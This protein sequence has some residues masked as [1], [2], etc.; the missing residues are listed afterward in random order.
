MEWPE[1]IEEKPE[2]RID[3]LFNYEDN[4]TK[5]SLIISSANKKEL[6]DEFK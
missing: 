4:F 5:R 3:L 1:I 2:K 6:I